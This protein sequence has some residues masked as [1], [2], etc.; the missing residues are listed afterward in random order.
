MVLNT[1]LG[2]KAGCNVLYGPKPNKAHICGVMSTCE[3]EDRSFLRGKNN[4]MTSLALGEN[5]KG[6]AVNN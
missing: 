6:C 5:S 4:P 2:S 3:T 1:I